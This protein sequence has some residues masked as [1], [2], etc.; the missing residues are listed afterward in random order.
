M[1]GT[2]NS[3]WQSAPTM[4]KVVMT[5]LYWAVLCMCWLVASKPS[6]FSMVQTINKMHHHTQMAHG[7]LT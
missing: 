3:Q 6:I 4:P 5:A 7:N 1:S 2:Y